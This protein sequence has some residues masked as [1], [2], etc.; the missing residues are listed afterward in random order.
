VTEVLRSWLMGLP[1]YAGTLRGPYTLD[2]TTGPVTVAT[3]GLA[4]LG[5]L[6]AHGAPPAPRDAEGLAA[7][8]FGGVAPAFSVLYTPT[9]EIDRAALERAPMDHAASQPGTYARGYV[10]GVLVCLET[11]AHTLRVMRSVDDLSH[12]W[13][14]PDLMVSVGMIRPANPNARAYPALH[15]VTS[16]CRATVCARV[17]HGRNLPHYGDDGAILRAE[18]CRWDIQKARVA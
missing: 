9:G 12:G 16:R 3:N 13:A 10:A 8:L 2:V 4:S 15:L 18:A 5:V 17:D 6:G 1:R 7:A 11:V 14:A